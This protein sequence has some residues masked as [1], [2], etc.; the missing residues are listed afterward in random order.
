MKCFYHSDLDGEA[1]AAT[2]RLFHGDA[3]EL[4]PINYNQHFPIEDVSPGEGIWIVDFTLQEEGMWAALMERTE[5]VVW[6]DHHDDAI[7]RS[8]ADGTEGLAGL[9]S[10]E[11]KSGCEL[12]WQFLFPD[13]DTPFGICLIGDFD[14]WRFRYGDLTREFHQGMMVAY[15][16]RPVEGW[17]ETWKRIFES[18]MSPS[19]IGEV[20][21]IGR[22]SLRKRKISDSQDLLAYAFEAE[23][24]GFRCLV[25]N[26]NRTGSDY[27]ASM[28]EAGYDVYA[29]VIFDGCRWSVS[30]YEGPGIRGKGVHLGEMCH[31]KFGGGGHPGAA[32]FQCEELPFDIIGK[33][34]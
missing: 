31:E 7:K 26:R 30:L 32:G 24:W 27:F 17:R 20:C 25:I 3:I 6:I 16:T 1:A 5:Y 21:D 19:L 33:L 23:L 11:G 18:S 2:I 22:K 4:L 14:T 9:R 10:T 8:A 28:E 13:S 29:P 34:R 12:T 15:D